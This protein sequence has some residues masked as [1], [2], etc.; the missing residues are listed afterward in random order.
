MTACRQSAAGRQR[1][2]R[3]ARLGARL[4]HFPDER[5]V[6]TMCVVWLVLASGER[7]RRMSCAECTG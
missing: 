2:V 1:P 7:N 6:I 3:N 5:S 4:L